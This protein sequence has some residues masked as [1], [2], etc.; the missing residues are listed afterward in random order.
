MNTIYWGTLPSHFD[1]VLIVIFNRDNEVLYINN[2]KRQWELTG[3]KRDG[4]ETI[5]ET[6]TR[7]AYEEGGVLFDKKTF[8]TH[9][10]YVLEDSHTTIISSAQLDK[11]TAIPQYSESVSRQFCSRP[12]PKESL[13]FPD[14]I[15]DEVFKFL[16]WPDE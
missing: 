10:Y 2:Q 11:T 13:S 3:G 4:N 1:S 12:M 7:E 16:G 8:M 6:A 9:G 5:I 15:Y 14:E